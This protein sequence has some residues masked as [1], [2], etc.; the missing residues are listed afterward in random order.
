MYY[1]FH[2]VVLILSATESILIVQQEAQG[3]NRRDSPRQQAAVHCVRSVML[4]AA[5][6]NSCRMKY[7]SALCTIQWRFSLFKQ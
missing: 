1:M 7:H 5:Q 3:K 4:I 2:K 6:L